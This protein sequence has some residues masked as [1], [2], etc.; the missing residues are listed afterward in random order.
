MIF[1]RFGQGVSRNVLR[2]PLSRR[3]N[4]ASYDFTGQLIIMH[5]ENFH[6]L[7]THAAR[8]QC[9]RPRLRRLIR[10]RF[11]PITEANVYSK[12]FVAFAVLTLTLCLADGFAAGEEPEVAQESANAEHATTADVV[13][14]EGFDVSIFAKPPEVNY[15]VC[16]AAA[17]S[18]ELFIG[19]DEQGSLGK[20]EGRGR[21]VRCVDTDGD[22]KADEF[23][24]FAKMD[25]PRGL[26]YD[27]HTLWVLHP[28]YLTVYY[29]D[30]KDGVADREQRL[31]S[32][33]STE[34]VEKRGAD[35][36]TNGIRLG[37]DGWIYIAVGDFGMLDAQGQDDVKFSKRGGGVA[38]IRPDGT[39][40]EI[41]A[42]GLRNICDVAVDPYLNVFTRDNTNDGGGWDIRVSHIMQSANYGYPSW[43]R[44][45]TAETMPPLAD[46]G[47][48]SG[49]GS[50]FLQDL[51]WPKEYGDTLYTCDWGRN[52]VYAHR[53]PANG[54]TFDAHQETFATIP[55]P[56][57]IDV[58]GSGRMY[59]SSWKGGQFKYDGVNIG[60][61]AQVMP[62]G[63]EPTTCPDFTEA[64]DAS[65][66]KLLASPS[67]VVRQ[68]SQF[69]IL[70]R[71][72]GQSRSD[73]LINL[74][75]DES[76]PLY[77]RVAAIFT[78]KQLD[79]AESTPALL[80]LCQQ[81][82]VRE[83]AL[84]ALTDRLAE[85][86][87]VP[88]EP[89]LA[90]L[91]DSN[92]RVQAQAIISLG[93]LGNP[94]AAEHL[95]PLAIRPADAP[96][97][98][99]NDLWRLPDP[100]R[101]IPH[102]A[103][104]ALVQLYAIEPCLAALDGP[105]RAGALAALKYMHS[106]AVVDGLI[107]KLNQTRDSAARQELLAT[108]IRLH[109]REATEYKGDWWGTRPDNSGPYY[110][111]ENWEETDRIESVVKAAATDADPPTTQFLRDQLALHKVTIDGMRGLDAETDEELQVAIT[112]PKFDE[113]NPNQL[114]NIEFAEALERTLA[115]KGRAPRGEKLFTQQ[116]CIAC[117]T[118]K[119]GQS[120]KG[121]H[122]VDIGK[123]YK[124]DELVESILKPSVKIAQGFDTLMVITLKGKVITGFVTSESADEIN[125]RQDDGIQIRIA[126]D[127]IDE[128]IKVK[129]SA[130]PDG[131]V[132]NL[133][134]EE[135]ADLLAYLQK[136]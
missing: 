26:I 125:L 50:M 112:I 73:A 60:F 69:E 97:P 74:A 2:L 12:L 88:I 32:G 9:L 126:K 124:P 68:H 77:A 7:T 132:D 89:F 48:G 25:H 53:L 79:G 80:Q 62:K 55:R 71:G 66:I 1:G 106:P 127:D 103:V 42:W 45:F 44:N 39:E 34:L 38:R 130:M 36:T 52:E 37:I 64:D 20:E 61:V 47:G 134:P 65:L 4:R 67:A 85:M 84:R 117:H 59:I 11:N 115:A 90:A 57:D 111:R 46:Y 3:C 116:A 5:L 40:L 19:I 87:D 113:N 129:N 10:M 18:G 108:L 82:S 133:T 109:Q 78:L 96:L 27:N 105:Y 41:Y 98:T 119:D 21:V 31:A 104:Q 76:Q 13:L 92:P 75:S 35:H 83:F 8:C 120:P 91:S 86:S 110:R 101:V 58:D 123:R 131:I 43:Y 93:R 54:A 16:I 15:P 99:G 122:L 56:T 14:V 17:P 121:P 135:L 107:A 72:L 94:A 136:L 128:E 22:G 70:R 29:D 33:L 30:D 49:C 102:L 95:L 51:R 63:F 6:Q 114:G 28:P 118:T 81:E 23:T 24:T 100:A